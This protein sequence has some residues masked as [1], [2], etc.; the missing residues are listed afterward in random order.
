[1]RQASLDE[2]VKES[3]AKALASQS[4]VVVALSGGLDSVVLLH[5]CAQYCASN[6]SAVHV[7]H[8]ISPNAQSWQRH[9][10]EVCT[11]LGVPLSIKSLT[12][13]KKAR[14]SLEEQARKARYKA[15][16]EAVA[17]SSTV[18]LAQHQD[19]QAE[20]F[21]LQL[22]RGAGPKGLS[23]MA[24]ASH[25]SNQQ[26]SFVR[27]LLG[28]SRAQLE[29]YARA[30]SLRWIED[31]SNQD[32]QFDR[33]FLRH[34]IM[35]ELKHRWPAIAQSISRSAEHCADYAELAEAYVALLAK[36][37]IASNGELIINAW[38]VVSPAAQ[39]MLLRSF[40]YPYAKQSPSTAFINQLKNLIAAK[41]DAQ[42]EC[43]WQDLAVR[44]Y[45][46]RLYVI[47][48]HVLAKESLQKPEAIEIEFDKNGCFEHSCLPYRI[49]RHAYSPDTKN[50]PY[51]YLE[52]EA[53]TVEF[54]GF[55]RVCK[56]DNKRPSKSIKT[57]LQE[58]Q[59][60]PWQ[61]PNI[62]ILIQGNRVLALGDK[63]AQV[64]D[65]KKSTADMIVL[66]DLNKK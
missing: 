12:I 17:P 24:T 5:L 54:G 49:E 31:E 32:T 9:C 61:R 35:P 50:G 38:K 45:L 14:T 60:P 64:T 21:I 13:V 27:P 19:D 51:L 62:P 47:E 41:A 55:Q 18:F 10:Q 15:I 48:P 44:R 59:I 11:E 66:V 4:K 53:L 39:N 20:T 40:L 7:N 22:A 58:W 8:G 46:D 42:G 36:D 30:H 2:H 52:D 26:L 34:N 33:N 43:R 16:R 6:L 28:F 23:A 25:D 65:T 1:M 3:I 29:R 63:I 57:W 37:V 56:L